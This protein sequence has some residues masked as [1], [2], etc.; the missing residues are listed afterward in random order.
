MKHLV[1]LAAVALGAAAPL[2]G[3]SPE[4]EVMA[5][6]NRLFDGMRAGDSSVVRSVFHPSARMGRATPDGL[7]FRDGVDSFVNA[8]GSPH[9]AVWDEPIWDYQVR[10]DGNL[11]QVWTKYAFY[12]GEEFSHCGV[13]AFDLYQ[14]PDG[15]RIFQ[16][17]DTN[18][19]DGCETPPGR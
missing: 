5:V 10:V 11:A 15:W 19:R 1:I 9:D 3:Q 16:L 6:V 12:L 4:D 7:R 8:V 2:S 17:V 13:D 18:Q 14:T